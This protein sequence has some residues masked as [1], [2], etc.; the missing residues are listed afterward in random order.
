MIKIDL[1]I[2][3]KIIKDIYVAKTFYERFKGLMF[4]SKQNAFNLL[5]E[6]CNSVHTCFMNFNIDIYC[7]DK[8]YKIVKVYNNVKPF[9]FILPIKKVYNILEIPTINK[10][11]TI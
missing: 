1:T 8:S 9:K 10:N 2:D 3:N 11:S 4:V 6:K 5:I 7:L